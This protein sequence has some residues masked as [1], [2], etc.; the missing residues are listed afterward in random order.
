MCSTAR[1]PTSRGRLLPR[2]LRL[3]LCPTIALG[4]A[5]G[6]RHL[7]V[8]RLRGAQCAS[9]ALVRRVAEERGEL[10]TPTLVGQAV[11]HPNEVAMR[12]RRVLVDPANAGAGASQSIFSHEITSS[13]ADCFARARWSIAARDGHGCLTACV[14]IG[15]CTRSPRVM[16]AS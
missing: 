7:L 16:L 2:A 15:E 5:G 11:S 1:R 10:G 9:G 14:N 8:P 13:G 12:P 6:T 4:L 3:G